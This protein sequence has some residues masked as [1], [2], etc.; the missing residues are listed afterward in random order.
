MD[1]IKVFRDNYNN[2]DNKSIDNNISSGSISKL[3]I[4]LYIIR[5]ILNKA[6]DKGNIISRELKGLIS[7]SELMPSVTKS[8]VSLNN[9]IDNY[10]KNG[11]GNKGI[12]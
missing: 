2:R 9:N 11:S 3:F 6:D 4:I 5:Y 8:S 12:L 10:Y 7:S 1:K